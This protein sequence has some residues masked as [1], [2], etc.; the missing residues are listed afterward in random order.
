MGD[1]PPIWSTDVTSA[2]TPGMSMTNAEIEEGAV[3]AISRVEPV[4]G[5]ERLVPD[6]KNPTPD[7]RRFAYQR[8]GEARSSGA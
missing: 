2:G 7:W 1:W 8:C 4:V 3:D 6:G 5:C